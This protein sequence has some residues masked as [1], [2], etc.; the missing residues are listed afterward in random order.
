MMFETANSVLISEDKE[1][2]LEKLQT[3]HVAQRE[4]VH[5]SLQNKKRIIICVKPP[6]SI[7]PVTRTLASAT[8]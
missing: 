7:N 1:D 2:G 6:N 8:C 5:V 3:L 4:T